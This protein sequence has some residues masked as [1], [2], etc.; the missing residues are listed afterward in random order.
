M[1]S[2]GWH[3]F[4]TCIY[5][6]NVILSIFGE[7]FIDYNNSNHSSTVLNTA[8]V[9]THSTLFRYTP[10]MPLDIWLAKS[11]FHDYVWDRGAQ[12]SSYEIACYNK[13]LFYLNDVIQG[14][15]Y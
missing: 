11:R 14:F 7:Y 3:A 13:I 10:Y 9:G 12:S 5:A 8:I 4:K 2:T 1:E 6:K 15:S